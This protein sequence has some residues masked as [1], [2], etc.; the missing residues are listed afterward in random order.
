MPEHKAQ[1]GKG[2]SLTQL[3]ADLHAELFALQ[4]LEDDLEVLGLDRTADEEAVRLAYLELSKRY[5]PHRFARY[6]SAEASRLANEIYVCIQTAYGRVTGSHRVPGGGD[7]PKPRTVRTQDDLTVSRAV[8]LINFHQYAAA[9]QL[10]AEVVE[11]NPEHDDALTWFYLARARKHKV[12]GE[13]AAAAAAYR[14]LLEVQ[15]SHAEALVEAER[16]EAQGK[17]SVWTRLL[18][19]GG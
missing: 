5:H 17:K 14:E 7:A 8:E 9:E 13:T 4:Q 2:R 15:P 3:I 11:A 19:L 18:K 16:L 1:Q 6:R 12:A 10:L